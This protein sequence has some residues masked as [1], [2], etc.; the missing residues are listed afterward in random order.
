MPF[1]HISSDGA[2]NNLKRRASFK[3]LSWSQGSMVFSQLVMS[4]KIN[5][6][7]MRANLHA[8]DDVN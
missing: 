1:K 7:V 8:C 5:L 4:G 2:D 3:E 6:L